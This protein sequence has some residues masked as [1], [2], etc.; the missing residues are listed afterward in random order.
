MTRSC[1][2]ITWLF[3]ALLLV[4]CHP[5]EN[6][7]E[8][9]KQVSHVNHS[10]YASLALLLTGHST[11][12]DENSH[13]QGDNFADPKALRIVVEHDHIP[14]AVIALFEK[15]TGIKVYQEIIQSEWGEL[16]SLL[17]AM[18]RNDLFLFDDWAI[19]ALVREGKLAPI[20][21]AAVPN[22]QNIA[23]EFLNL[24]IDPENK[25]SVPYLA[26]ILGIVVNTDLIKQ[27]V[28]TFKDVFRP[29]FK[30]KIWLEYSKNNLVQ[31]AWLT[32]HPSL[33]S[34]IDGSTLDSVKPLMVDWLSLVKKLEN[35][36][37]MKS[38]MEEKVSLGIVWS[39]QAREILR[40]RPQYKW[41]VPKGTTFAFIDSFAM[42]KGGKHQMEAEAFIN[43]LLRPDIGKMIAES[44]PYASPN[45]ASRAL[46]S[47][48]E[49][50][51]QAAYPPFEQ[52]KRMSLY[53]ESGKEQLLIDD[54]FQSLNDN[55]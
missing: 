31:I 19:H 30:K 13:D 20:N 46:I 26:G 47:P 52:F 6:D 16:A 25:Y 38:F 50:S 48:A 23:P 24:P 40:D 41:I 1:F 5:K 9:P 54:W 17:N 53:Q 22:L 18:G 8:S 42:P 29:E 28:K 44:T 45:A 14:E 7:K 49:L 55:D 4:G 10:P 33:P 35:R 43:F 12:S 36:T 15:E 34:A 27:D 32:S 21:H 2:C 37:P 11:E 3:A 51:N 39:G